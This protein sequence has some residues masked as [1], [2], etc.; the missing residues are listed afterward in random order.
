MV[1]KVHQLLKLCTPE[2][3]ISIILVKGIERVGYTYKQSELYD[4]YITSRSTH[5]S[6][7][8]HLT[9]D[10]IRANGSIVEFYIFNPTIKGVFSHD[11]RNETA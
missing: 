2:D 8:Y 4:D 9:V 3:T 6:D 5:N 7:L 11:V 10:L 1:F